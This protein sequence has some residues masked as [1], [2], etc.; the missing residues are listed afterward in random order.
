MS[1]RTNILRSLTMCLFASWSA[2]KEIEAVPH[3]LVGHSSCAASTCHGGLAG[4]E[5]ART[6]RNSFSVWESRDPHAAAGLTLRQPRSLAI[7][8]RLS[9]GA[10][11]ADDV[12]AVLAAR[13][14]ACHATCG[15]GDVVAPRDVSRL[16]LGGVSC[17]SCHGSASQW[18]APHTREDWPASDRFTADSGMLDTESWLSRVEICTR[19]HVGTRS[20][21][22]LTRDMNHDLIAAG[23]PPLYFSMTAF[24]ASLPPHWDVAQ[25]PAVKTTPSSFARHQ[26]A[27]W[28]TLGL[29]ARLANERATADAAP[30]PSAALPAPQP[31]LAEYSCSSCHHALD[32]P[33]QNPWSGAGWPDW[34]PWHVAGLRDEL[35]RA[36]ELALSPAETSEARTRRRALLSTL[37]TQAIEEARSALRQSIPPSDDA[38]RHWLSAGQTVGDSYGALQWYLGLGAMISDSERSDADRRSQ[39]AAEYTAGRLDW[40]APQAG[41]TLQAAFHDFDRRRFEEFRSRLAARLE[42]GR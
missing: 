10:K 18:L 32:Q 26:A 8:A 36:P 16:I 4:P 37:E 21:D 14:I 29:V 9:P 30:R 35:R 28:Q 6:W 27:R 20:A 41:G 7:A 38:L 1:A 17:E 19:C 13:C 24:F 34:N 15:P 40:T 11:S 3:P 31:E 39:F 22:G 42:E 5:D 33:I 23:H 12:Q 2:A 25:D